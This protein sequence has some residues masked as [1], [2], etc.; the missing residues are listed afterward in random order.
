MARD[1]AVPPAREILNRLFQLA[2]VVAIVVGG[3]G[4]A[5]SAVRADTPS[6]AGAHAAGV[7]HGPVGSAATVLLTATARLRGAVTAPVVGLLV[8]TAIAACAAGRLAH[9]MDDDPAIH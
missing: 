6:P 4:R 7:L 8:G 3:T 5:S 9:L 2:V 1:A